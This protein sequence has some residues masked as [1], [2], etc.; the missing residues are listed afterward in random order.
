MISIILEKGEL[1]L[2]NDSNIVWSWTAFRFQKALRDQYTNSFN[3]PKT[4]KNIQILDLYSILDTPEIQY[5]RQIHPVSLSLGEQLIP[6]YLQIVDVNEK[7]I[8]VCLYEDRFSYKLKNKTLRDFFKDTPRTIFEWNRYSASMYPLDFTPYNYGAP[9]KTKLPDISLLLPDVSALYAQYHPSKPINDIFQSIMSQ[10]GLTMQAIDPNY[11]LLAS[12]RLVCPQNTTQ[13]IEF[14]VQNKK[15][16]N[17]LFNLKGGQHITNDLSL[18]EMQEITFNRDCEVA[19]DIFSI[20]SRQDVWHNNT[21]LSILINGEEWN[22]V[23][24]NSNT[25]QEGC[26]KTIVTPNYTTKHF[27]AGDKL[28]FQCKD[29]SH[30][31]SISFVVHMEI[32]DYEITEDDY[33]TQLE[34]ELTRPSLIFRK[35]IFV[36]PTYYYMDLST[37]TIGGLSMTTDRLS[38][39]YFGLYTNLPDTSIGDL[40]YSMQWILAGKLKQQHDYLYFDQKTYYDEVEGQLNKL[41]FASSN[42]GQNNYVKYSDQENPIPVATID[43]DWLENEKN[44]HV[45]VFKFCYNDI[46]PQY[47]QVIENDEV[48]YEFQDFDEPVLLRYINGRAYMPSIFNFG[49]NRINQSKEVEITLYKTPLNIIDDDYIY[50]DG[51]LYMVISGS[52]DLNTSFVKLKC[53]YIFNK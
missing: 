49:L 52:K 8:T 36:S 47:K 33:S 19:M 42:V 35:N 12:K 39:A 15:L 18:N 7:D 14:N 1:E 28:S 4:T 44:L 24:I 43:N 20:W 51:R 45:N 6:A 11:R 40:L 48:R 31:A 26:R 5:G 41:I 23:D 13:V 2:Y 34:Y 46:V 50:L 37:I 32:T 53:L 29:T 10:L 17:D 27:S 3:I 9:Y 22:G 16:S 38:F 21:R 25:Y 30:F